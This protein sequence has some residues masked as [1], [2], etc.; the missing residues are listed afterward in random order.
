MKKI[1]VGN[2]VKITGDGSATDRSY[3]FNSDMRTMLN[4]IYEVRQIQRDGVVL[5]KFT[6]TW[7]QD[8]L[9]V[10]TESN[11]IKMSSELKPITINEQILDT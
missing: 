6:F 4:K 8:D 11:D 5:G 1:V 7:H 3:G 10:V 2:F 9:T